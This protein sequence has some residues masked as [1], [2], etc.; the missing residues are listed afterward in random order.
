MTVPTPTVPVVTPDPAVDEIIRRALAE[1][2]PWGD[3][4][5]ETFLPPTARAEARLAA[6]EPGVLSGIGVFRFARIFAAAAGT[7]LNSRT[8]AFIRVGRSA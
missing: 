4:T 7:L 3:V 1:D 5:S 8:T 2:A 6:R